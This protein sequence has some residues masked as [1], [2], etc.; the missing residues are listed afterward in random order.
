MI[1][2]FYCL[3]HLLKDMVEYE[4]LFFTH[5]IVKDF[6]SDLEEACN[7]YAQMGGLIQTDLQFMKAIVIFKLKELH[8]M[9]KQF[10]PTALL[11]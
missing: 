4:E 5:K 3:L 8:F 9:M 1:N 6:P 11:L 2:A 10:R 7:F